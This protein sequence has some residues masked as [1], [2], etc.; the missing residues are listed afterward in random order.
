MPERSASLSPDDEDGE[1]PADAHEREHGDHRAQHRN[2]GP[3][4]TCFP[5]RRFAESSQGRCT[6][7]ALSLGF[8]RNLWTLSRAATIGDEHL[9]WPQCD[10]LSIR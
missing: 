4:C 9:L 8:R 5:V 7:S 3:P 10:L 6:L 1:S 2:G